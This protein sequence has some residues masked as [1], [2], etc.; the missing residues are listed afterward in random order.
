MRKNLILIGKTERNLQKVSEQLN[1][2]SRLNYFPCNVNDE[3]RLN[4]V[5]DKIYMSLPFNN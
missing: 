5:K 4:E 3:K 1:D 2:E